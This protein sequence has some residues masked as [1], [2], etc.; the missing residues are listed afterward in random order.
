M[1]DTSTVRPSELNEISSRLRFR[2]WVGLGAAIVLVGEAIL[3][4]LVGN[5]L[6][7]STN[8][9]GS[10][11]ARSDCK[12][13]YTSI[14]AGPVQKRDNLHAQVDSLGAD[15]NSQFGLALLNLE[16]GEQP[17]GS[18]IATFSATKT[19]LDVKRAQLSAA[20]DAVNKEPTLNSATNRGFRFEGHSYPAC[21]EA[22]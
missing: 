4:A 10:L 16:T 13:Q 19:Q 21:P 1:S 17:S 8:H 11:A 14:L 5:A 22:Q 18:V 15:L 6:I 2:Q 12:T 3:F 7:N 20:I 9:T